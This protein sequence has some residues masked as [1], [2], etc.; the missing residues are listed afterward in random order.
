MG[1]LMFLSGIFAAAYDTHF[2]SI[3]SS[4]DRALDTS[5]ITTIIHTKHNESKPYFCSLEHLRMSKLKDT[6]SS[7]EFI[8]P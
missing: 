5:D 7:P 3:F 2:A 4:T 6:S 1:V 8:H